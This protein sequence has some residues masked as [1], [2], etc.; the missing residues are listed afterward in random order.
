VAIVAAS[1]DAD[2][3]VDYT[4]AQVATDGSGV[5]VGP[6]CGNMLAGVG[7]YAIEAGLVAA[8]DGEATVRIRDVNTGSLVEAVV[9]TP[10]SRVAYSGETA[11]DGVSGTAAPIALNFSNVTGA[12]TGRMFPTGEARET[13]E[14]LDVTCID[15]ATPMVLIQAAD[16]GLEGGE[17]PAELNANTGLFERVERIRRA[18]GWRMGLGDVSKS[19]LPKVA[20]LSAPAGGGTIR[21]R[22]LTPWT[23]HA[24]HAVTGAICVAAAAAAPGTVAF[25]LSNAPAGEVFEI[26]HPAGKIAIRLDARLDNGALEIAKAGV[27]RTARLIMRGAVFVPAEDAGAAASEL[28][29]A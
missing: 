20:I 7:P 1:K 18:A 29:A 10:G 14:G 9:Q 22:Y 2:A 23:A 12:K 15:V 8:E 3:D 17:T 11:I 6:S 21:S 28:L 4:F 26:E 25:D 16:L 5:D 19:V 24:A 27:I 13:I